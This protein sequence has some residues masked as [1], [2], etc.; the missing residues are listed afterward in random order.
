MNNRQRRVEIIKIHFQ[1]DIE[2]LRGGELHALAPGASSRLAARRRS[3]AQG[4]GSQAIRSRCV[5]ER[6]LQKVSALL[7]EA[8]PRVSPLAFADRR[9]DHPG[10]DFGEDVRTIGRDEALP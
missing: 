3:V 6:A 10:R 2:Y 9:F 8:P 5:V 4:L 7:V 1:R